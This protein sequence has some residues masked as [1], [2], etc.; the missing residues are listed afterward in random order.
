MKRC[1]V[2]LIAAAACWLATSSAQACSV[3]YGDTTSTMSE[4]LT[5]AITLMVAVVGAVLAGV[6]VFFVQSAKKSAALVAA[7]KTESQI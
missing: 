5:W 2:I 6:V 3:C 1:I 7:G 4:G